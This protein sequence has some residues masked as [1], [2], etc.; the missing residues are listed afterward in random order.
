MLGVDFLPM[1]LFAIRQV[2]NRDLG[3]S[4]HMLVY[5]REVVGP[6]DLLCGRLTGGITRDG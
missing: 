4:P 6:L 2:P 5:G 1:A 3:F